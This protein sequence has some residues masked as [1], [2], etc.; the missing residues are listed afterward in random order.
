MGEANLT[1]CIVT[2]NAPDAELAVTFLREAGIVARAFESLSQAARALDA[3]SGCLILVEEALVATEIPPL[4]E[5]L[6]AL[7]A[8]CDLPLV[9]VAH[10]VGAL[11][12]VV[13]EAFPTSGNVTLLER[14]LNPHSLVSA[15]QVALRATARQGEVGALLAQRESELRMRDEFLAMLAHE[16]RNPLAP[17]RNALYILDHRRIDDPIVGR[18]MK[19]LARQVEH[20]VRMVDDLLDVSRL[21]HGKV[22]LKTER[23]D[24]NRVVSA[25]VESCLPSVQARGHQVA[26]HFGAEAVPVDGDPVRLEQVVCNLVNNAAKFSVR[27]GDITVHTLVEGT[28]GLVRVTDR[29]VG[30]ESSAAET[31]FAPFLQIGQTIDR[32]AG[33]L[34][35]GLTIVRRLVELHGGTVEAFSAGPGQGARFDVRIPLAAAG[36][37]AVATPGT[38]RANVGPRRVV[39]VEDNDDVRETMHGL[40]ELWGHEVKTAEDGPSGLAL[41]LSERPDAALLDV[42]LPGMSGYELARKIRERLPRGEIQLIA[43]TGY[44]QPT[45]RDEATRAGFDAHLLKPIDPGSLEV[46]L[47]RAPEGKASQRA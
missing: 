37:E 27:P 38:D 40:L 23:L 24:L 10:D 17:M 1:A 47:A 6:A 3:A 25:A 26:V 32:R 41:V 4:R 29:G 12:Q 20:M 5:A 18:N 13:P 14:P 45:D 7:P 28:H 31:L 42:G 35:M 8:W 2:P 22:A 34:G 46:L 16:L 19:I 9:I 43:V 36:G 21:E 39:V 44:G 30:F 33:G 15:V 11:T